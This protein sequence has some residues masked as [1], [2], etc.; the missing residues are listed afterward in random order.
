VEALAVLGAVQ[1]KPVLLVQVHQ[2][3]DLLVELEVI[4]QITQVVA[5]VAQAL[6]V[7]IL[8]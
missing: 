2:V 5:E 6:L 7:V 1:D 3:K 8:A 4:T